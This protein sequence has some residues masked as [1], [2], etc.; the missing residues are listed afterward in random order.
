MQ[1]TVST[2]AKDISKSSNIDATQASAAELYQFMKRVSRSAISMLLLIAEFNLLHFALARDTAGACCG[3]L[4]RFV[5][6]P[7]SLLTS[8]RL[9]LWTAFES[10]LDVAC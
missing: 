8:F 5:N 10:V 7:L 3:V 2:M 6:L 4:S 9:H 1:D